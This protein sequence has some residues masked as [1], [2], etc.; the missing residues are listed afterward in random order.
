MGDFDFLGNRIRKRKC[1]KCNFIGVSVEAWAPEDVLF[2]DIAL[3][4]RES[5]RLT[6]RRRRG[7]KLTGHRKRW[8]AL[9]VQVFKYHDLNLQLNL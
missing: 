2:A 7:S 9:Q 1:P 5:H 4:Y 6:V 8:Y 3:A